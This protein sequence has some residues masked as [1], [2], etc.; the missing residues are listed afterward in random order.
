MF[1]NLHLKVLALLAAFGLWGISNST[2]SLELG[3]DVPVVPANVPDDL[4]ITARSS[5][6]VNIRVRGSN[7]SVRRLDP[8]GLE[9][10]ID[11]AGA[12]LGALGRVDELALMKLP[13]G[14]DVVSRSPAS[15]E[16][17]LERKSTRAVKVRADLEGEPG[18][19]FQLGNV[20]VDPPRLRIAGARSEVLRLAEVLTETIDLT[21]ASA[22]LVRKARVLPGGLHVWLDGADEVT[23]RVDVLPI[24]EP[25]EDAQDEGNP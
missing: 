5:D 18:P 4:V 10:P 22:P 17:T 7:A 24:P 21:G 1:R 25:P 11:L 8:V 19:G 15:L 3:F 12:R 23:V 16:F 20:T 13:R 6:A 14:L 9:Y 2:A